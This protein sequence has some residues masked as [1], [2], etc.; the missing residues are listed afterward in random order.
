MRAKLN[1]L[2]SEP[3]NYVVLFMN[4][5]NN[6]FPVVVPNGPKGSSIEHALTFARLS[7]CTFTGRLISV[8][9]WNREIAEGINPIEVVVRS[10]LYT[11]TTTTLNNNS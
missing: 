6:I 5:D 4:R 3:D 10:L 9:Q 7:G 11:T 8:G 1:R 2:F